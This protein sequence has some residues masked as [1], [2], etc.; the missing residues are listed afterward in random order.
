[1]NKSATIMALEWKAEQEAQ[2]IVVS[3][4]DFQQTLAAISYELDHRNDNYERDNT[5]TSGE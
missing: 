2:D 5:D 1:M 3:D 4:Q